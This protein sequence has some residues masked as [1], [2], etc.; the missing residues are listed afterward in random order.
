[1]EYIGFLD[2][3]VGKLQI[4]SSEKGI[5]SISIVDE[6]VESYRNP[7]EHIEVC[8]VQLQEYFD[9][10][11]KSF[12]VSLDFEDAPIFYQDVWKCLMIIP[13]GKTRTYFDV[14]KLLDNPKAVRAVGIAN[15]K[16]P[17]PFIIPCHRVIGKNGSLVGYANG[18]KMK[19]F[20]L[21]LE[22]PKQ[23]NLQGVLFGNVA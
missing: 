18:L 16:N 23:F 9:S 10:R 17:I 3:L 14:A 20:L 4:K 21:N 5:T 15:A 1:M 8:K 11:R 19:Q 6:I 12:D 2:S 22:N 7:N 13:Y